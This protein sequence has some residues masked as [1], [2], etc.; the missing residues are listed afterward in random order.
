MVAL[1]AALL[2]ACSD[3]GGPGNDSDAAPEPQA[4]PPATELSADQAFA[5]RI[6]NA[7]PYT[8]EMDSAFHDYVKRTAEAAI[9][10]HC[11]SCHGVDLA[12]KPGVPNLVDYSWLWGIRGDEGNDVA[13]VME[14]QQ[15]IL[16]GIRNI[17]CPDSPE[18]ALYNVCPDTRFSEM[19][20]Y[21]QLGSFT[22]EQVGDVVEFVLS[23][24]GAEHDAEA[25]MRGEALWTPCTECHGDEGAGYVPYGGPDLTDDISL[26]GNDRDMLRDV[27]ANGRKGVCPPF[28]DKLDPATIKALAVYIYGKSLNKY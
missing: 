21:Q 16:Y 6:V 27:I 14:L 5:V 7:S 20:G 2:V 24:S 17:D 10:E 12:G 8:I 22:P 9:A 25:A 4:P 28:A 13:A 26:Y 18:K 3:P 1:A 15:T 11:A 19:P 23:L